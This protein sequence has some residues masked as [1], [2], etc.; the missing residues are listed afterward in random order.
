[1]KKRRKKIVQSTEKNNFT[2]VKT[3]SPDIA[4]PIKEKTKMK[5]NIVDSLA[6]KAVPCKSDNCNKKFTSESALQYHVSFAHANFEQQMNDKNTYPCTKEGANNTY[7]LDTEDYSIEKIM[8]EKDVIHKTTEKKEE[9]A[10]KFPSIQNIRPILPAQA[11]GLSGRPIQPKPM[12]LPGIS[13]TMNF[14]NMI[15]SEG[16]SEINQK[17]LLAEKHN[18][19]YCNIIKRIL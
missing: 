15:S 17:L 16:T 7:K 4:L 19:R 11:P 8:D 3:P 18:H 5:T 14:N 1:M 6:L 10:K 2:F 9:K 12:L 13:A